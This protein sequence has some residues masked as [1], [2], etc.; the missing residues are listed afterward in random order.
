MRRDTLTSSTIRFGI[1]ALCSIAI[2]SALD[3]SAALLQA[4][5]DYEDAYTSMSEA[6][7]PAEWARRF[8]QIPN[9]VRMLVGRRLVPTRARMELDEES[10]PPATPEPLGARAGPSQGGRLAF[11]VPSFG[12][13]GSSTLLS[14]VTG[15]RIVHYFEDGNETDISRD[16]VFALFEPCHLG[17][18]TN[19]VGTQQSVLGHVSGDCDS[20]IDGL[21]ACDFSG[22]KNL[23]AWKDPRSKIPGVSRYRR[24][25][26]S[27]GLAGKACASADVT[28]FKTIHQLHDVEEDII[29]ML[30]RHP[31]LMAVMPVRDPRAIYASLVSTKGMR[32]RTRDPTRMHEICDTFASVLRANHSQLMWAKFE[33]LVSRP[34]KVMRRV[35]SFLGLPFGYPQE[36]WIRTHFD[37]S[38]KDC[39]REYAFGECRR[40]SKASIYKWKSVLNMTELEVFQRR[41]S[42]VEVAKKLGYPLEAGL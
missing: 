27:A 2:A 7:L 4:A 20:M 17:D 40:D 30:E 16:E 6:E 22:I 8:R 25:A 33:E 24:A 19:E 38:K 26:F 1:F 10:W 14:M 31:N 11:W 39:P 35:Y 42:C 13:T 37:A 18:K 36:Q 12:R 23:W 32:D 34:T 15:P 28:A 5:E 41:P 3:D 29:P 9:I 21:A